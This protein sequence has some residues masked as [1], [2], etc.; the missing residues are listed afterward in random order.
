MFTY[1]KD[2]KFTS[3][4]TFLPYILSYYLYISMPTCNLCVCKTLDMLGDDF[5]L[6]LWIKKLFCGL[7]FKSKKVCIIKTFVTFFFNLGIIINVYANTL[8]A[9]Q[10]ETSFFHITNIIFP[11]SIQ[12]EVETLFKLYIFF[13]RDWHINML[14]F[15]L[16]NICFDFW[17]I[18][19]IRSKCCTFSIFLN[20]HRIVLSNAR[21][22]NRWCD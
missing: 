2:W 11:I 16:R 3:R 22:Q 21:R 14:R 18:W 6:T 15:L 9:F 17:C 13:T 1:N 5:F 8:F 7:T 20:R 10:T 19:V 12:F 4:K